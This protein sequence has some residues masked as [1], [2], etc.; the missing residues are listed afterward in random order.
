MKR[1][2]KL[3]KDDAP[4]ILNALDLNVYS[5]YRWFRLPGQTLESKPLKHNIVCGD[6]KSFIL[7]YI[8]PDSNPLSFD[9]NNNN[10]IEE[11]IF[12]SIDNPLKNYFIMIQVLNLK[13]LMNK[14]R[15]Y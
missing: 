5:P 3:F 1:L 4:E 2:F 14:L 7:P 15:I 13:F 12:K 9:T 11:P 10:K 6:M 8:H